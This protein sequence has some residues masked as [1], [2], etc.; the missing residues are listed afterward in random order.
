MR[1]LRYFL[2]VAEELS[3]SRAAARVHIEAS[4]LSR[5][6]KELEIEL[7]ARLLQR[8]RGRIEL[9]WAGEVFREEARKMLTFMEGARSR[10]HAA[11]RGYRGH[12]RIGLSDSL[13]HPR[14]TKLL[15]KCREEEPLTEVRI[16]EMPFKEMVQ[17]LGHDQIDAGFTVH[18]E[19]GDEF[20]KKVAWTDRPSIAVPKNHPL[21]SLEK[22]SLQEI[23]RH[24]LILYH[25]ERC[26]GG[27]SI[28]R[29]WFCEYALPMPSIAEYASGHESM[30]M[31]VAA[32]YGVG[33]ALESQV[34]LYDHP[35][36]VIRPVTDD[37][38]NAVTFL[39]LLDKPYSEQLSRF[40]TRIQRVGEADIS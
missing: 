31:L 4:P 11:A 29:R 34:K 1:H 18:S 9:T 20:I 26:F 19:L 7:G 6:I 25:P 13:V 39:A 36:V 16:I 15:A 21:L 32:G 12:L 27:Y 14:L 24:S 2:V 28:I 35:D 37:V 30:M 33:F 8:T 3:F 38:P 22:I 10:V 40:I 5:A 23:A 17:A